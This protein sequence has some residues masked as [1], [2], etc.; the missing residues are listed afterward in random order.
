LSGA[1]MRVKSAADLSLEKLRDL[2]THARM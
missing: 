1:D 2:V